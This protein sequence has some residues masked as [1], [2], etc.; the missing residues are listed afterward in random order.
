MFCNYYMAA[1][2]IM[3]VGV[4]IELK[5]VIET[6]PARLYISQVCDVH[7]LIHFKG[8]AGLIYR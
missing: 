3:L 2:V 4:S 6:N 5:R 7:V 8:R 1:V